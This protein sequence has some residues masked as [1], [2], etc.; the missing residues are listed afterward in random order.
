[1]TRVA[2]VSDLHFGAHSPLVVDALLDDL[3]SVGPDVVAVS[4]DLTQRARTAQFVAARRFLDAL[5]CPRLVVPGNHDI[6]LFDV[7][8]R[9]LSPLTRF[10]RHIGP[11]VDPFLATDGLALLGLNT[12]RS[13]TWKDGRLSLGQIDRIRRV[14]CPL[15]PSTVRVL[16]THH[17]F[18]PP[19]WDP[20]PPIVGRAGLALRA[21]EEC[22]VDLVLSGHLHHGYTGD[23]RSHHLD[24]R[25]SILVAQAGTATS[26]RVR[27][28]PNS[29]NLVHVEP[30]RITFA[31]RVWDGRSFR[32]AGSA[33]YVRTGADWHP[34]RSTGT[35]G[36]PL[37]PASGTGHPR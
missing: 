14:L 25:R 4:G 36:D 24:V 23:V 33:E 22:G 32:E 11:E 13:N 26:H 20:S 27:N 7:A 21:V 10:R 1:M 15:S 34:T 6:P 35:L 29:Y 2:H 3:A 5:P 28:E 30:D 31:S 37:G 19:P 9:F 18:L 16:V 8:R 12:A 17:P